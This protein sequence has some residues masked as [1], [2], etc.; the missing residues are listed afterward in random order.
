[1]TSASTT[2]DD[3]VRK[4]LFLPTPEGEGRLLL[5]IDAFTG[6][7]KSLEGR[8]KLAKLDFLLRYPSYF[9][10]ALSIR[11]PDASAPQPEASEVNI[12]Q[13][14]VRF[15]YGPWDPAYFALLGSL[16]GRGLVEPASVSSGVGYRTTQSGTAVAA[17]LRA[18]EVW[19]ETAMR[20][21]LLRRHFDLSGS[22]LKDF[23]YEHFP[24]VSSAAW[25]EVL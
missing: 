11:A 18:V 9:R 3:L 6:P 25:G 13:R 23:V 1:M 10:R 21:R 17:Q 2:G 5:L 24:E 15:R 20:A 22:T 7:A 4:E 12:E 8:T 14:M 16:I 19:G